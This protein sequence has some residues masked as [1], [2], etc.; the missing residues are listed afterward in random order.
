[1]GMRTTARAGESKARMHG[2][3]ALDERG[4]SES[5]IRLRQRVWQ[6]DGRAS[7][8]TELVRGNDV[9]RL[10]SRETFTASSESWTADRA[11]RCAGW[12]SAGLERRTVTAGVRAAA[13]A[14]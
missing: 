1:M 14:G 11:L 10:V 6:Q 3:R 12:I 8:T 2:W 13:K 7:A 9:E 5:G 4:R